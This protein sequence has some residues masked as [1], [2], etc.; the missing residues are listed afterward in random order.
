[1]K[2]DLK[3]DIIISTHV[4]EH[5]NDPL[6]TLNSLSKQL[7]ESGMI[8]IQVPLGCLSE[9]KNLDIPFRHNNFFSEESLYNLFNKA[10]LDIQYLKTLFRNKKKT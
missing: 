6:R 3:F 5:L 9:W 8:Y 1:M 7:E 4:F 10:D 2:E